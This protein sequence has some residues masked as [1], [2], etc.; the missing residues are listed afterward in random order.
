M[1][2]YYDKLCCA[3]ECSIDDILEFQ[4]NVHDNR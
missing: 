3:M 2:V 1:A 4:E